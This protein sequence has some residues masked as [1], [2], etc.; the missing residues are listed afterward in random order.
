M[1]KCR[2][3]DEAD[4]QPYFAYVSP[5]SSPQGGHDY[6]L[7]LEERVARSKAALVV[8]ATEQDTGLSV[9]V[10]HVCNATIILELSVLG[11][12]STF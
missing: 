2:A 4:S 12:S 10:F 7:C 8:D 11:E 6:L 5:D 3:K 1:M 9:I